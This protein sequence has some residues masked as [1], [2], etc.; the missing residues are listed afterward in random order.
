MINDI[1]YLT[2]CIFEG[3]SALSLFEKVG[4]Q[5]TF[6]AG[7]EQHFKVII[8]ASLSSPNEGIESLQHKESA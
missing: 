4:W 1:F 3:E 6:E 7:L 2:S 5:T 8:M